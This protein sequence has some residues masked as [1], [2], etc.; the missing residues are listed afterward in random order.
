V[1]YVNPAFEQLFAITP[2]E[3]DRVRFR[4][5]FPPEGQS[6]LHDALGP[7]LFQDGKWEGE[8]QASNS[9]G[10][11]FPLW[12]RAGVVGRAEGGPLVAFGLMHDI[13]QQKVAE[14]ALRQSEAD[15]ASAQEI[16][17]LG[18]Y[19]WEASGGQVSWSA[20]LRRI[21]SIASQPPQEDELLSRVH[22][23][24]F[25]C[26][27]AARQSARAA[28]EPYSLEY[29]IIRSD[30]E[31]R[32]I[33]DQAYCTKDFAGRVIRQLGTAQDITE[34]KQSETQMRRAL[35]EKEILL[36]E[37]YH[38]TKNN[39][40]FIS[41]LL[42]FQANNVSDI[43]QRSAFLE[44]QNRIDSLALVHKKLY[45]SQDLSHICLGDYASDLAQLALSTF[46]PAGRR[47]NLRLEADDTQ[48]LIDTAVPCGLILN[49]LISNA[50]KHAFS[51]ER[52][53]QIVIRISH[54]EAGEIALEVSDDGCGVRQDFDFRESGSLGLAMVHILGE[55]Q[56]K[57]T[58]QF[59]NRPGAGLA[60]R[61]LFKDTQYQVRV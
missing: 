56:L 25:E 57:G 49:E 43:S 28:G 34:R 11:D 20:E 33:Q 40:Q 30:G 26:V 9:A 3:V 13:G 39:M 38:R 54:T 29:R 50:L 14:E 61:V 59:E 42:A 21:F 47:V 17:H 24:D 1:L 22:P 7:A 15:L 60:C 55:R 8:V 19:T 36:R 2:K 10:R 46:D 58:V 44:T 16:A 27:R 48:V 5:L 41:S 52:G 35:E 53:G 18:S 37:L 32:C 51:G 6:T 31:L 4:G 45:Q 12:L 23:E